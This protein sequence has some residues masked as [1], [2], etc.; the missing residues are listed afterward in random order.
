MPQFKDLDEGEFFTLPNMDQV[1]PEVDLWMRKEKTR[2]DKPVFIAERYVFIRDSA[3]HALLCLIG[4]DPT[5]FKPERSVQ[6]I[7]VMP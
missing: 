4:E 5:E 7:G 6:R 2:D 1:L 3:N